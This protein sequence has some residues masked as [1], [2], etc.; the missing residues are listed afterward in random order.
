MHTFVPASHEYGRQHCP[1][2]EQSAPNVL[3]SVQEGS[4]PPTGDGVADATGL[5]LEGVS[6][7]SAK[8]LE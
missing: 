6:E 5:G 3:G 7:V 4:P 1:V 8:Y 2:A